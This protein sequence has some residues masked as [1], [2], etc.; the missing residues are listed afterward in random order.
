MPPALTPDAPPFAD[1][2]ALRAAML[3]ELPPGLA[4]HIDR[5]VALAGPLA[6]RHGL[7]VARTL[8]AAQAHD[9]LRAL[10]GAALLARAEAAGLPIDPVER[11]EPMLLHGPLG[12]H[13][14]V[15][16]EWVTDAVVLEAVRWHTTGHPDYA[17]EAWAVFVADKVD[18]HKVE[19]WPA[20]A[21]V[22]EFAE[23]SLELAALAYLELNAARGRREG[24]PAY[25]LA[26]ATRR[27]LRQ[28][29]A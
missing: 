17:P 21:A 26:E 12:A 25:P 5:V 27:A 7:D 24:W 29:L 10:P 11:A 16:R 8:L 6:Q 28:R 4:A 14:L 18:P 20:L 19:R 9:L 23:S 22:A 13:E 1:A 2:A 3:P 15:A